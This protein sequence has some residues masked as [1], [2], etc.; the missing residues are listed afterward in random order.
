M[1]IRPCPWCGGVD[2]EVLETSTF[3]WRAY[4]CSCGVVGPEIR[5]QTMGE[6]TPAQR[7]ADARVNAI[8]EWNRR[9]GE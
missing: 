4:I 9:H 8:A 1:D 6:G 2:G 5:I 7:E 3:R